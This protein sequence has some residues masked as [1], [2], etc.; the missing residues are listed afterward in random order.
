MASKNYEAKTIQT[1]DGALKFGSIHDDDV[2]SS[3]LLQGQEALEYIT[4]DQ[5]APRK[6]WL[7]NRCRGRYQ[8]VSGDDIEKGQ[9]AMYFDAKNGDIV[10][11]TKGRIRMEAE[12]I[13]IIARGRR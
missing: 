2:K 11:K 13:D 12:N 5:T 1:K 8:V 9:P 7:S 10:I 3:L 4:F 6:R